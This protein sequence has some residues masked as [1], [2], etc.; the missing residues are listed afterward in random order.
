MGPGEMSNEQERDPEGRPQASRQNSVENS[1]PGGRGGRESAYDHPELV[2]KWLKA[3]GLK[4]D[5][6]EL[7]E[8][9]T[10][11]ARRLR[12]AFDGVLHLWRAFEG[13]GDR[14]PECVKAFGDGSMLNAM[15]SDLERDHRAGLE[16]FYFFNGR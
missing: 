10:P 8:T 1:G 5:Q 13:V 9:M 16:D 7:S 3:V 2:P 15:V 11:G 12:N 6:L 4:A 14:L